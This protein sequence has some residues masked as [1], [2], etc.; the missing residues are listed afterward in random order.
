MVADAID[1]PTPFDI[2][3]VWY[4]VWYS[5]SMNVRRY[6]KYAVLYHVQYDPNKTLPQTPSHR[7]RKTYCALNLLARTPSSRLN[8]AA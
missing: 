5:S 8:C 1:E 2:Y 6:A 7:G 4:L 3:L